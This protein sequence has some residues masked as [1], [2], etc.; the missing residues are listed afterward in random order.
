M[1]QNEVDAF[2]DLFYADL[3]S[4]FSA[5]IACCDHCYDEFISDWP[6]AYGA[7]EAEFQKNGIPLDA[8]YS[9]SRLRE[10]YTEEEFSALICQL[11]CP[12]CLS[13]LN[14]NIWAY[15]L[16]FDVPRNFG[17]NVDA[18]VRLATSTPFLLLENEF[19]R[20][21]LS[22]ISDLAGRSKKRKFTNPLYRGRDSLNGPV[23]QELG[24]FGL[25]PRKFVS[26]GRY[27]HAGMPVLYL[28]SDLLTCQAE[29]RG[30]ESTVL[31]FTL[32]ESIHVLD[33]ID[34]YEQHR[35]HDDL[36]NSLVYSALLSA[37]QHDEGQFRPHYVVSRF[38]A[39]CAR[40]AGFQAIMYPSTR[41]SEKNFN[42]VVLDP[43]I[44]LEQHS[45]G[46]RYHVL[47]GA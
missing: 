23:A 28:A 34:P 11:V 1:D 7:N 9:G 3:D 21:V 10:V 26:E 39:D 30:V 33:L 29:L 46:H 47:S 25:A 16:P 15:E 32:T 37:K 45:T 18:I 42:L 43:E 8:F 27:N 20:E 12:R 14:H 41:N 5:D 38:V 31:E 13:N 40:R 4:W 6:H 22:A 36:L 24:Q 2:E 35:G 19:C 17:S 44:Q